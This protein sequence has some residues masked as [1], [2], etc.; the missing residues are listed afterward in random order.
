MHKWYRE[1]SPPTKVVIQALL[2]ILVLGLPTLFL[3]FAKFREVGTLRPQLA[4]LSRKIEAGVQLGTGFEGPT[5]PER[6]AWATSRRRLLAK[7]PPD[8]DLPN[9]VKG[10]TLLARRSRV[11]GLLITTSPRVPLREDVK[12][13]VIGEAAL[14]KA[15]PA[16]ETDLGYYPIQVTFRT[17]YR[18]LARFLEGV[19]NLAPLVTVAS[20]EIRRGTP[21]PGVQMVLRAYHSGRG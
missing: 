13:L 7:L 18:D 15:Q 2:L 12:T 1:L 17:T 6:E 21:L 8:D 19:E 11:E 20:M 4:E 9:L 5:E 10:L 14:A 16:L 3:L